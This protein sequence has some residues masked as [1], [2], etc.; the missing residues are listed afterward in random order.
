MKLPQF[1]PVSSRRR[2]GAGLA[3]LALL[4]HVRLAAGDAPSLLDL[5]LEEL[6]QVEIKTDITSI[7]AKPIEEQPGIVSVVT[8]EQIHQT[9][10]N[11]LSD[12]LMLVPGFA[13]DTDVESM[14]GLTFRGLQGQEGK[15]LL[16]V[17]G[18]EVN[19][20]LYGSLPILN[21]IPAEAVKQVEIIRG[22]GSAQYG[23]DA[24][25]AV[26]RVTTL[27]SS[28]NGGY[29]VL[30]PSYASGRFSENYAAGIGYSQGDWRWSA[31]LAYASTMLSN[32]TYVALDGTS[33][34]L[35]HTADMNPLFIDFGLGWRGLDVKVLYDRYHYDDLI[36]YGETVTTPNETRFDS[37]LATAK[38]DFR[39]NESIRIVPSI[40][41]RSQ[42]PWYVNGSDGIYNVET[43][44]YEGSLTAVADLTPASSLLVG[45]QWMRDR[46]YVRDSSYYGQDPLTYFY[47]S[48]SIAYVDVAEFAQ[49]DW[50]AAWANVSIGGRYERQDA[51]GGHFVP[52]GAL[53]KAWGPWHLKALASQATRIPA[54]NVLQEAVGGPL[55][56]E[57]TTNYEIEL[58]YKFAEK[59]TLT[60]NIFYM[61]VNRPIVFETLPGGNDTEGYFNG[62][63]ISTAGFE[64]EYRWV[65]GQFDNRVGYSFYRAVNNDEPYVRGDTGRFLGSPTHK[66]AVSSTWHAT[67]QLD[68]NLNGYWLSPELTYTYPTDAL[69]ELPSEFVMNGLIEYR[70]GNASIGLGVSNLFDVKRYA[71]Q[72]YNGGEAPVPLMGR[73]VFL[74][75]GYRF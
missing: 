33:V 64:T 24:G 58:G 50:D 70:W 57:Q 41:Y 67:R 11:D 60:G 32:R 21:H 55:R 4:A 8:G 48:R 1:R 71:P 22:P 38:Y 75:L 35:T 39:L 20:P 15:V 66:V 19:E 7:R 73:L 26:V 43:E 56:P 28:Q 69:T 13:L 10:A 27:D 47:G 37:L 72:P 16:I 12:V 40:S 18:M 17:N 30:T 52:R 23:G 2:F 25:L 68:V 59:R 45:A 46:A 42:V 53:T 36:D 49:Y 34:N 44:R 61:S 51:V 3:A 62:S 29:A 74:K 5:S 6:S 65:Q 54:I 31:N 14:I 63:K 9:G